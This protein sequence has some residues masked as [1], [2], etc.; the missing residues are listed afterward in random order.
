MAVVDRIAPGDCLED[1][2]SILTR[3]GL[4]EP[5][6]WIRP[7]RH[8]SEGEKFR[9]RLARAIALH[10]HL[11]SRVP[12]LCDEFGSL[13]HRRAARAIAYG[14]RRLTTQYGLTVVVASAHD[15]ILP[16]LQPD[17]LIR[18]DGRGR[19]RV[20][21]LPVRPGRTFSLRRRMRIEAGGKRDYD[22]FA[23]MHYRATDE[24]GFVDKVFVLR[25]RRGG[26]PLGIV[27]YAH[28]PLELAMRNRC[29]DNRFRGNPARLNREMRILRRLVIHPDVRGC[30]LGHFLVRKT[31]PLA[32]TRFVECLASM[33]AY[34][35]VFEKAGMTRIGRYETPAATQEAL[36]RLRSMG[37]NPAG[38]DFPDRIARRRRVRAIVAGVVRTWY[39][40]TTGRGERRVE[41]QSPQR[42][43]Q[44]FR[45]LLGSR[46]VYYLWERRAN[47]KE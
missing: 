17:Q 39:E 40:G 16:D 31:L 15:D 45:A 36:R 12:L 1:A 32:G 19:S 21:T 34:N 4:G 3:C 18:F 27:V 14:L 33:G 10:A 7:F 13:L 46:P 8:L 30:G 25:E 28:P 35:P 47:P 41:K 23:A 5:A 6:L 9:A 26:D 37:I 43:A 20:E 11:S 22:S 38:R 24:L 29:T 2:L 44:T 42:L